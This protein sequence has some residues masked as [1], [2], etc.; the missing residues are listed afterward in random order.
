MTQSRFVVYVLFTLCLALWLGA[1]VFDTLSTN[2]VWFQSPV[3]YVR[4]FSVERGLNPWPLLTIL[5][6]LSTILAGGAF[7]RYRGPGYREVL[8][9]L[10]GTAVVLLVTGFYFVPTLFRLFEEQAK[11]LANDEIISMSRTWVVLNAL[12]QGVLVVLFV[13]AQIGLSKMS[14]E[15]KLRHT[16]FD[17]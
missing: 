7:A 15:R 12:R 8:G 2:T 6:A 11:G 3:E 1:G 17:E 4:D 9:A 5:L 14:M 16:V 10:I 13:V